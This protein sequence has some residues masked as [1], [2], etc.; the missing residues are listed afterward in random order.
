MNRKMGNCNRGI[1]NVLRHYLALGTLLGFK[2]TRRKSLALKTLRGP[3]NTWALAMQ[4]SLNTS[5]C[6]D[7]SR[8][9]N[10]SSEHFFNG[11]VLEIIFNTFLI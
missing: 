3:R 8:N 6:K 5:L 9:M 4:W 1:A 2:N 7:S 11:M 10:I